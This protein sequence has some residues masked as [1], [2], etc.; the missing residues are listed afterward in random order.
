MKTT[1]RRDIIYLSEADIFSPDVKCSEIQARISESVRILHLMYFLKE[2]FILKRIRIFA[3]AL[4]LLMLCA[5]NT[6]TDK[7]ASAVENSQNE[8]RITVKDDGGQP[9][10]G[11]VVQLCSDTACFTMPTDSS[12][13]AA[14]SNEPAIYTVHLI[15]VPEGYKEDTAEYKT[16]DIYSDINIVINKE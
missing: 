1:Y 7:D 8:Y 4:S 14:F 11:A 6:G 9:V 16:K 10:E 12:G 2:A 13:T 5:C 15:S 3:A